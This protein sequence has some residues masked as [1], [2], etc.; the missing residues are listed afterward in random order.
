MKAFLVRLRL[1]QI[2]SSTLEEREI[3]LESMDTVILAVEAATAQKGPGFS[4]AR[5][6]GVHD[7]GR[8]GSGVVQPLRN[9]Q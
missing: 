6:F 2:I 4:P 1:E 9:K 3:S 5:I 7:G 8:G